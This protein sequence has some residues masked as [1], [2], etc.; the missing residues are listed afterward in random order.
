MNKI[1]KTQS[2]AD[3]WMHEGIHFHEN[4]KRTF[5]V[6]KE[7]A[8]NAGIFFKQAQDSCKHGEWESLI[9]K[10]AGQ[11][12][13]TTIYR[14]VDFSEELL[15]WAKAT[16]PTMV[17]QDKL[18]AA[19]MKMALLSPKGYIA[20]CRQL[21]KM[22]KFGEYD[23]VKY[24]M[25]KLNGAGQMEFDFAALMPAMDQLANLA[26]EKCVL[27]F[28][29]GVDRDEYLTELETKLANAT[30]AVRALRKSKPVDLKP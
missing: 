6:A 30:K 14:Y 26:D 1:L 18:K 23:E 24:R 15:G 28:P 12:S 22:R 21:E 3:K 17:G 4:F 25:K 19:A 16:N 11:I 9:E 27:K 20:L 7:A 8:L 13:R 29:D 2:S 10:Y 5:E